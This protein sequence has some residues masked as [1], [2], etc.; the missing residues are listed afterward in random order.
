MHPSL[1]QA[2]PYVFS[3]SGKE[4]LQ[5]SQKVKTREAGGTIH[6]EDPAL[7]STLKSQ[8][9]WLVLRIVSEERKV[10]TALATALLGEDTSIA[11]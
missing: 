4:Q 9:A 2:G 11:G 3:L 5:L 6:H 1:S 10:P 7:T 8:K